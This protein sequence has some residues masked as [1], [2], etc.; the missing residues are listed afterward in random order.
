MQTSCSAKR[1][2]TVLQR[3]VK[4]ADGSNDCRFWASVFLVFMEKSGDDCRNSLF[5]GIACHSNVINHL[6]AATDDGQ[7]RATEINI[8]TISFFLLLLNTGLY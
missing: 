4:L 5:D 8:A 2:A 1:N 7:D 6:C 3:L